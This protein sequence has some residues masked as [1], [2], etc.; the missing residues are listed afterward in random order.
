ML[1]EL[2]RKHASSAGYTEALNFASNVY[3]SSKWDEAF[4]HNKGEFG[5]ALDCRISFASSGDALL[6]TKPELRAQAE[7]LIKTAEAMSTSI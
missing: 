1:E 5:S 4:A 2:F 3:T 6:M 7:V